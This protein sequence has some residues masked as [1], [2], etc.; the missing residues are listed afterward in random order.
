MAN[1][2][3]LDEAEITQTYQQKT[4]NLAMTF[5]PLFSHDQKNQQ[6]EQKQEDIP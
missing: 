4:P 1:I 5:N 2:Y 3:L 6:C